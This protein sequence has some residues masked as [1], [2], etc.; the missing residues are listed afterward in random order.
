MQE[1]AT[2]IFEIVFF[3]SALLISPLYMASFALI[4]LC[5]YLWR[6]ESGGFFQWLFPKEMY[7]HRSTR[8]DVVLFLLNQFLTFLGIFA[9]FTAVPAFAAFVARQVPVAPFPEWQLS[10][11]ALAFLLFVS[12]DFALYWI[13]RAHH[14]IKVIWP[15]H[16]VHHS[17]EVLTPITTY[18]QHPASGLV[19]ASIQTVI[20][21]TILGLLI[22][23]FVPE[24]TL[25]EIAGVNAFV[26]ALNLTVTNFQ[27]SHVWISFG[28][29]LEHI[30]ISPAQHQVHHSS[31]RIH[32]DK[33]FG[34]ALAIW[35]WMFGTLYITSKDEKVT[36]GL[37]GEAD[38]PL[39]THRLWPILWSPVAR[40]FARNQ[41]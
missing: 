20:V 24:A 19:S 11:F 40:M 27:H 6:K 35:D 17:A 33:N 13:H 32:Y 23:A 15:L 7:F 16:A 4:G 31:R 9:R 5:I 36:F 18:R 21:G 25:L 26:M 34:Q 3:G 12:G 14:Q 1:S 2:Q 22:G 30:L 10:P 39:M 28:P 29:V 41:G 38:A 37:E 8:T